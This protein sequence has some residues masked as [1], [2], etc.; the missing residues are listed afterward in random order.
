VK[1]WALCAIIMTL[2]FFACDNSPA[3]SLQARS[4][5]K[6]GALRAGLETGV[7]GLSYLAPGTAFP[8]GL[9]PD[10]ARAVARE[11][12]GDEN[13]VQF[14]AITPQLRGPLLDNGEVDIVIA[15]YTITEE[16]KKQYNFSSPYY[17]DEVGI[18]ARK[19]SGINKFMDLDGRTAGV[20]K[21][22]TSRASLETAAEKRGIVPRYIEFAS[23]PE[24]KAA[25]LA[26]RIDAFVIDTSILRGYL[27]EHTMILDEGFD[28]QP[29]GIATKLSN[30]KLAAYLEKI[31]TDMRTNGTLDA[32]AGA[33][34]L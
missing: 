9:E 12:L 26:G 8:Q 11:I 30:D 24:I 17:T 10:L 23:H 7:P 18:M 13:A 25:L 32:L 34:G 31:V 19:D 22:T 28:P 14:V 4:I 29:Y 2:F 5:R 21:A 27:D 1:N 20:L 6:R 15:H 16:R 3:Q 33:W